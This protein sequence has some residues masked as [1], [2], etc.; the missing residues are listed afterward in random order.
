MSV[1]LLHL[2]TSI[3]QLRES[4]ILTPDLRRD[5]QNQN[6]KIDDT[7]RQISIKN[8]YFCQFKR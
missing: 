3:D 1:K 6:N 7:L 5:I 2:K 4:V 8:N